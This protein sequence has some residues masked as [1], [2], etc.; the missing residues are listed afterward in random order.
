LASYDG[1]KHVFSLCGY[2]RKWLM[3]KVVTMRRLQVILVQLPV[4]LL[5]VGSSESGCKMWRL[6][7]FVHVF[8]IRAFYANFRIWMSA[9][10][11][12][13]D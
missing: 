12:S 8:I 10:Y 7:D 9:D 3:V 1:E 6:I 11:S 5:K 4:V 13:Y 2:I